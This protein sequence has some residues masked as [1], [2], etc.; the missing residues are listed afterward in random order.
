MKGALERVYGRRSYCG[1]V[2]DRASAC[3]RRQKS[4][5]GD[6]M[7]IRERHVA[8]PCGTRLVAVAET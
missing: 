1:C 7:L 2:F 3:S 8:A 4:G 5:D 6:A